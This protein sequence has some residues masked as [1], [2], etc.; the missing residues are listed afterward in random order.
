MRYLI[1]KATQY[2]DDLIDLALA[3]QEVIIYVDHHRAVQLV[4]FKKPSQ[5]HT[6]KVGLSGN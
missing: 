2:L 3:C 1:G 4:P 5:I 6:A